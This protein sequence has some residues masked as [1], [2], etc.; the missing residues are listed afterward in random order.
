MKTIIC[1]NSENQL[2][3]AGT[4]LIREQVMDMKPDSVLALACG[5][6]MKPLWA[7]LAEGSFRVTKQFVE[8]L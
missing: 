7:R 4:D 5:E 2:F 3:E 6:T 8:S 1:E